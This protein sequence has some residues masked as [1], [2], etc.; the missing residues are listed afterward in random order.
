MRRCCV[1]GELD[2]EGQRPP[3]MAPDTRVAFASAATYLPSIA[4]VVWLTSHSASTCLC[5]NP[6]T[7]AVA[8]FAVSWMLG[9][10][11]IGAWKQVRQGVGV[12]LAWIAY[13]ELIVA[14]LPEGAPSGT[15]MLVSNCCWALSV[16]LASSSAAPVPDP[17][18]AQK[19]R[20]A[21]E[22]WSPRV[23][24]A[25]VA[26]FVGLFFPVVDSSFSHAHC[27]V[28]IAKAALFSSVFSA[29]HLLE[30]HNCMPE[31]H[32]QKVTASSAWIL[33]AHHNM[34]P[35]IAAQLAVLCY[36][37]REVFG[38]SRQPPP[39]ALVALSE[40]LGSSAW[41][42]APSAAAPLSPPAEPARA[43]EAARGTHQWRG[44]AT[45]VHTTP[46]AM[47]DTDKVDVDRLRR[48]AADKVKSAMH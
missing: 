1:E 34:L 3:A 32:T 39:L 26:I 31:R 29:V 25:A 19:Q 44:M 18:V 33:L 5:D 8:S 41:P 46:V 38:T 2:L 12:W 37:N 45:G 48:A 23:T 14:R 42:D 9:P 35:F 22:Q 4:L 15:H 47:M 36:R 28:R 27:G 30:P 24:A 17:H 10:T 21:A 7:V 40:P 43:P 20:T 16:L 11:L 13:G 6:T